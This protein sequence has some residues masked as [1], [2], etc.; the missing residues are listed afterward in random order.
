MFFNPI[1]DVTLWDDS[2]NPI[3]TPIGKM[4]IS[5][6]VSLKTGKDSLINVSIEANGDISVKIATP[7]GTVS[8]T[9]GTGEE[10][11]KIVSGEGEA[12]QQEMREEE[13]PKKLGGGFEDPGYSQDYDVRG[14]T[15][16]TSVGW[17]SV[18]ASLSGSNTKDKV[19]I[20]YT[21]TVK[22]E[23]EAYPGTPN[24]S[25]QLEKVIKAGEQEAQQVAPY[26]VAAGVGAA[27]AAIVPWLVFVFL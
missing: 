7:D 27:A 2:S 21:L 13:E 20:D 6:D 9:L 15:V 1:G 8:M 10:L 4:T 23:V 24:A 22:D 19:T 5:V 16:S 26:V 17:G 25:P 18:S 3:A 11:V 14:G 12:E